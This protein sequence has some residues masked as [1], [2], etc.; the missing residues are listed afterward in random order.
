MMNAA[1]T[2]RTLN[3]ALAMGYRT[4]DQKYQ[5]GYISRKTV[6]ADQPVKVASGIRKGQL[7]VEAPCWN[8]T[9]YIRRIYLIKD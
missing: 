4:A 5:R 1:S 9:Q 3:Y 7:Y 8:S 6:M 2:P